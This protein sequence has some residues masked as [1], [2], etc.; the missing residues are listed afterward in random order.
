MFRS[1]SKT[2]SSFWTAP[3]LSRFESCN[4][5]TLLIPELK[6]FERKIAA[7][8]A[9]T[10]FKIA[11]SKTQ[12]KHSILSE[13]LNRTKAEIDLFNNEYKEAPVLDSEI[14][15]LPILPFMD[16][17]DDDFEHEKIDPAV[18][19]DPDLKADLL[20]NA[21]RA[22][23]YAN[24]DMNAE[25]N[26][27][28]TPN[29]E[30]NSDID[31][32]ADTPTV[33]A[34]NTAPE[35]IS[36]E[37]EPLLPPEVQ[38]ATKLTADMQKLVKNLQLIRKECLSTNRETLNLP[39]NYN[40]EFAKSVCEG[41]PPT[42]TF[43]GAWVSAVTFGTGTIAV[44]GADLGGKV[45]SHVAGLNDDRAWCVHLSDDWKKALDKTEQKINPE[46]EVEFAA[47]PRY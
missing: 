24:I 42:A 46:P 26:F 21:N 35:F 30:E 13:F 19:I 16:A 31:L 43:I 18:E 10:D 23:Y 11:G 22:Y 40:R 39:R 1:F 14:E 12:Q 34:E 41:V 28:S 5:L 2:V 15:E 25:A 38:S 9:E 37:K 8:E 20:E 6:K 7:L 36:G 17:E 33:D 44:L 45:V 4:E 32:D 27:Y 47:R 29:N 3:Q